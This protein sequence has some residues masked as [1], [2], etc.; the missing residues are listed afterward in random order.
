MKQQVETVIIGGGQA[1]LTTSY[2]LSRHGREH[3]VLEQSAGV[4]NAW[5]NGRWDSFT[6]V[7][8]N[9]SFR[10]PGA[11]YDGPAPNGFMARDEVVSRFDQYVARY[12]LPVR[13][14]VRVSAVEANPAARG[15]LVTTGDV[16]YEAQNVV[17]A[18]GLHQEPR[19]PACSADLPA[20][21]LQLHTSAYRNPRSLPPGAVL[22]V[23]T[24]QSG[25]Q[26]AEEL[27]YS[28]RRVYL[29]VGSAGRGPRRY[30]GKDVYEW[31]QLIGFLDRPAD[32]LPTPQARF[33]ANPHISGQGGG[34]TLNLHQFARDGIRL[35][36][37]LEGVDGHTLHLA[38]D[39]PDKLAAADRFEAELLKLI[40]GYIAQTGLDAPAEALPVMQDGF[41][42]DA[43]TT[44]DLQAA[45]IT[46]VIW[47]TGYRFDFSLVRLPIFDAAGYPIQRQGIV[48]DAPG[49]FFAGLPWLSGQKSGL[50]LGVG[51]QTALI[52]AAIVDRA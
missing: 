38:A 5:R 52:A 29:C 20:G 6:L 24:G 39:L 2:H 9:W 23:G 42:V 14:G 31:L 46:A 43:V 48:P 12:Q 1:G 17:L 15:F 44:L 47:A 36:G 11:E 3:L 28:G 25:S 32:R 21:L 45:G 27:C 4:G 10:L 37:R 8:P 35:L 7:T 40:D 19:L 30:R 41:A 13:L 50:L 16:C 49:L 26:I 18:T 34:H 22:V 51:Q 33:A